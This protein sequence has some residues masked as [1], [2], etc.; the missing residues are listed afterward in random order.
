M[1]AGSIANHSGTPT[2]RFHGACIAA[3]VALARFV[4][5]VDLAITVGQATIPRTFAAL[6]HTFK[7]SRI[8]LSTVGSHGTHIRALAVLVTLVTLNIMVAQAKTPRRPSA[9]SAQKFQEQPDS[10]IQRWVPQI[11]ELSPPSPTLPCLSPSAS[12]LLKRKC[13]EEHLPCSPKHRTMD[14]LHYL[15]F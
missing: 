5:P 4:I 10:T 3:L 11:S 7:N 8:K 6:A 15:P 1:P 13:Q 2:I 12:W 9:L 14:E